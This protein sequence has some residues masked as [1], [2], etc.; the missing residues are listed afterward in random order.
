MYVYTCSIQNISYIYT[1]REPHARRL[2]DGT[3]KQHPPP[4]PLHNS[5]PHPLSLYCVIL[6]GMATPSV[7]FETTT[8][9]VVSSTGLNGPTIGGMAEPWVGKLASTALAVGVEM[10]REQ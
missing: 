8:V 1:V 5:I 2:Y 4:P 6:T 7:L 9:G 3:V 10:E